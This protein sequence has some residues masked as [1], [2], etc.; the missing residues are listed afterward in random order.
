MFL[1]IIATGCYMGPKTRCIQPELA[2]D[3]IGVQKT[4]VPENEIEDVQRKRLF[5]I[6]D[7]GDDKASGYFK[8][9][10][11]TVTVRSIMDYMKSRIEC[12][13]DNGDMLWSKDLRDIIPRSG[14]RHIVIYAGENESI[15]ILLLEDYR[16]T[17][18]IVFLNEEGKISNVKP[19]SGTEGKGVFTRKR[20]YLDIYPVVVR[21]KTYIAATGE[22]CVGIYDHNGTIIVFLDT[23]V[24]T[25][26]VASVEIHHGEQGEYLVVYANHK[27]STWSST[28]FLISKNWEILYKEIISAR[29]R[30]IGKETV[31]NHE[32]L[33]VG[34]YEHVRCGSGGNS[35]GVAWRYSF[36]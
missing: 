26:S 3:R 32:N 22:R 20:N 33:I 4:K 27:V 11:R 16:D 29:G 2:L 12:I 34:T 1:T 28:L 31:G 7:T 18:H 24:V 17:Q 8:K 30:W 36:P 13:G 10:R 35:E 15:V 6:T 9:S 21:G 25:S 23:P 14:V 19:L 5:N